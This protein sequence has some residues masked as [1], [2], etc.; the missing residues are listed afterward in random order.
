MMQCSPPAMSPNLAVLLQHLGIFSSQAN[1]SPHLM[2]SGQV[3]PSPEFVATCH[4]G[5]V[6][7]KFLSAKIFVVEAMTIMMDLLG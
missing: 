5:H 2:G 1:T 7:G 4:D 3:T 6:P